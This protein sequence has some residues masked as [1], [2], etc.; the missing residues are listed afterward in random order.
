MRCSKL[1]IIFEIR[2]HKNTN[3][4]NLRYCVQKGLSMS[5]NYRDRIWKKFEFI[6]YIYIS[7]LKLVPYRIAKIRFTGLRYKTSWLGLALRYMYLVRL[8][9]KIERGGYCLLQPGTCIFHPKGLKMGKNVSINEYCYIE[10]IGGVEIGSNTMIGHNVSILSNSHNYES[11]KLNMNEQGIS[12]K[13][14]VIGN[15]VWIG[16]KATI[17]PGIRIGNHAIIGAGSFVNKDVGEYEVVAGI[18]AQ[19]IKKRK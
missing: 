8:G 6:M 17:Q 3:L 2:Q 10:C 18:P 9:A 13:K 5:V 16:A 1:D 11:T 14:I 12:C 7:L 19:V 15:D 4:L